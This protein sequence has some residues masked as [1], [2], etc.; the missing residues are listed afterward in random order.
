M[1]NIIVFTLLCIAVSIGHA[2][3]DVSPNERH[4]KILFIYKLRHFRKG[5]D[6]S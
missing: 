4:A 5:L 1:R 2:A 6:G 3:E